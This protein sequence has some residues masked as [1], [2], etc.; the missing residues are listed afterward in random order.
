MIFFL[1]L[2]I[3]GHNLDHISAPSYDLVQ[4]WSRDHLF[5]DHHTIVIMIIN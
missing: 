3:F 5:G 1:I 2:V 4:T